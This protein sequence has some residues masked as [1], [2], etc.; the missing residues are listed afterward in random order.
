MSQDVT[1]N[2]RIIII[3]III[4]II[5]R[6]SKYVT[7]GSKTYAMD[8]IGFLYVSLSNSTVQH[9][10]CLD[11]RSACACSEADFT[12]HNDDRP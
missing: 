10:D 4:I 12:S 9:H 7:N 8:V 3:I 6:V 1:D 5:G 2:S 11:S